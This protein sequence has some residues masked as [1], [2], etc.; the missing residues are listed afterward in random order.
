MFMEL[1]LFALLGCLLGV[2]TGLTP[3]IH[4]NMVGLAFLW[5]AHI[6]NPYY[7]AVIIISMAI[8]HTFFDFMPSIFLGAPEADT[9]LSVLP[10]HKLLL[11]G[12]GLEAIYLTVI[13]GL[14]AVAATTLF[15]PLLLYIIPV[16]YG[17]SKP[18]I[19]IILIIIAATMILSE[20]GMRRKTIG[21]AVFLLSGILGII[22][23]DSYILSEEMILFPIFTGLF[24]L[25]NLIISLNRHS[26]I[27]EQKITVPRIQRKLAISGILKGLFAGS[28]VG[29]LPTIG[30][31]QATI[32]TQEITRKR[33]NREFL[34]SIGAI[35]T[36][37]AL[38]SIVALYTIAR[39]RSGAAVFVS[40]IFPYFGFNELLLLLAVT[41]ISTGLS[42][43][44]IL[45][46]MRTIINNMQKID[47]RKLTLVTIIF[48]FGLTLFLTGLYG[49]LI[50][51]V[52]TSIGILAP[53]FGVKRSN[54][55]GVLM[56]PVILF[57]AGLI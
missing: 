5:F 43:I 21:M 29:T 26:K 54:L 1:L 14:G 30:A 41:L 47:Y 3:G 15:F 28:I 7:I 31:A 12:R 24:G 44:L 19:H 53:V 22:L 17:Y 13:G 8:S 38:F 37:V 32:I 51:L 25:S 48:L 42:V 27:K 6:I 34:I 49:M 39:P 56:V 16:A 57:Y 23:L 9:A 10:G 33:N 4:V 55:M 36:I 40:N 20:P 18:H 2:F 52:S 35:N 46:L 11:E 45:K 50:L